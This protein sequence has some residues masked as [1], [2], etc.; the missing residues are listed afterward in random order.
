M[1]MY[2]RYAG[3]AVDAAWDVWDVRSVMWCAASVKLIGLRSSTCAG[4]S[5]GDRQRG[6]RCH[7]Q[8][9][10]AAASLAGLTVLVLHLC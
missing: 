6:W 5:A 9:S 4:V 2:V 3:A 1:H 10:W 8:T 7:L